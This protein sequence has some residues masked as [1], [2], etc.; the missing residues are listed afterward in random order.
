MAQG[1]APQT[2]LSH[3]NGL[4]TPSTNRLGLFNLPRELRDEIYGYSLCYSPP[5]HSLLHEKGHDILY[6]GPSVLQNYPKPESINCALLRTSHDV[7]SEAYPVFV[8]RNQ[9][10]RLFHKFKSRIPPRLPFPGPGV[11][12][13]ERALNHF[14]GFVMTHTVE[15]YPATIANPKMRAWVILARDLPAWC[16]VLGG[17]HAGY[18]TSYHWLAPPTHEIIMHNPSIGNE[19]L[20]RPRHQEALLQ[21]YRD[22]LHGISSFTVTGNV[23][24]KLAADVMAEVGAYPV[25]HPAALLEELR[26]ALTQGEVLLQGR[27]PTSAS[28]ILC[29]AVLR[30]SLLCRR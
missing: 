27:E 8:Q 19:L 5:S 22:H 30:L 16:A 18:F 6:F 21:P 20:L 15:T 3:D 9:F 28:N 24:A 1:L 25:P 17:F 10:V 23:N 13:S 26:D 2:A 14:P 7:Y 11:P 12:M 4:S 29:R